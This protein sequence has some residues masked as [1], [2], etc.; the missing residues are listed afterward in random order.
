VSTAI[1][2][3]VLI[4][5]SFLKVLHM[6]NSKVRLETARAYVKTLTDTQIVSVLSAPFV[7]RFS[8]SVCL[9]V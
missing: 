1:I 6:S 8:L 4:A 3:H 2:I 7:S 9:F 5:T